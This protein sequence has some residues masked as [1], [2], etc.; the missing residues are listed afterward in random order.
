MCFIKS[1]YLKILEKPQKKRKIPEVFIDKK[2]L[3]RILFSAVRQ[4]DLLFKILC[5]FSF[6]VGGVF[7][8]FDCVSKAVNF[9]HVY[10]VCVYLYI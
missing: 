9:P 8:L 4:L 6:L 3:V 2:V 7:F 5:T 10:I 1:D